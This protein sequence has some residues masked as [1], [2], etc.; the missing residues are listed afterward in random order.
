MVSKGL[1][2]RFAMTWGISLRKGCRRSTC[3][4]RKRKLQSHRSTCT[5]NKESSQPACFRARAE[6][7]MPRRQRLLISDFQLY[8]VEQSTCAHVRAHRLLPR[9]YRS[10]IYMYI[11]M[12]VEEDLVTTYWPAEP[13]LPRQAR[14]P[15]FADS[16]VPAALHAHQQ[17]HCL[18]PKAI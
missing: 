4:R 8:F 16:I 17:L 11:Y 13:I 14:S 18:M 7:P 6:R 1:F 5:C 9:A 10:Y 15:P 12:Y 3:K 2:Y